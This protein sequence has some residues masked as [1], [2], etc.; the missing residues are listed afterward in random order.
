M[1]GPGG[2]DEATLVTYRINAIATHYQVIQ[3]YLAQ[4]CS[5][6][7]DSIIFL[8][9]IFLVYYFKIIGTI[10]I[11]CLY[12]IFIFYVFQIAVSKFNV[13]KI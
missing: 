8:N 13:I 11:T 10:E 2:G 5:P 1:S 4:M 3:D 12:I 9:N 6:E 7:I